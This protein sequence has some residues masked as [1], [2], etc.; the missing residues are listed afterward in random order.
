MNPLE[1][2]VAGCERRLNLID[3]LVRNMRPQLAQA[4]QGI[5][6]AQD[7]W[8][9]SGG[10]AGGIV[11]A[12]ATT[13]IA[14]GSVTSPGSGLAR[15][16]LTGQTLTAYSIYDKVIN[17]GAGLLLGV[18]SGKYYVLNTGSCN[19]LSPVQ[20]AP[21]PM[22]LIT[23]NVPGSPVMVQ[24]ASMEEYL[25]VIQSTGQT[26]RL[27]NTNA[28]GTATRIQSAS[29]HGNSGT[30]SVS[31]SASAAGNTLIAVITTNNATVSSAS[32]G[33]SKAVGH[34]TDYV[35]I[36]WKANSSSVSSASFTLSG[37]NHW[38][39]QFVEVNGL[40]A[41]PSAGT[42]AN[43]A[44]ATTSS[45]SVGPVS[46]SG[47]GY[48]VAGYKSDDGNASTF[49]SPTGGFAL[50]SQSADGTSTAGAL[51]DQPAGAGS[52]TAGLSYGATQGLY[53]VVVP[54]HS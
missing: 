54:F 3:R 40:G 13:N 30:A 48:V 31:F 35:E 34:P 52:Y 29:N 16:V 50:V 38:T 4:Y 37:S 22:S 20:I 21:P 45:L 49:S 46:L 6:D 41:T 42:T 18:E 26:I 32:S 53:A 14:S 1:P 8:G 11:R 51:L 47:P 27:N 44:N 9:V 24:S 15:T 36:W 25:Q 43:A 33:W 17:S 2:R 5:R 12:V 19:D 23:G 10:T 7:P 39:V 28:A